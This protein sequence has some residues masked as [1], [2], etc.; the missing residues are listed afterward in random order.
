M[1]KVIFKNLRKSE[2]AI[3]IA[4][5]RLATIFK[6]FPDL[7]KSNVTVTLCMENSPQ[8]AGPDLFTVKLYSQGG[9]YR[10]VILEKSSSD[11]Y[12]AL[13]DVASHFREQLSRFGDRIRVKQRAKSKNIK[14]S[15][16]GH[17]DATNQNYAIN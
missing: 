4:K 17:N 7:Q 1:M 15:L 6:R 10:D 12:D 14:W 13:A 2:L 3:A 9:R 8:H 5:E 11:L 16:F